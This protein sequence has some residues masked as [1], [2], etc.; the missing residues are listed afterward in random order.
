MR[1]RRSLRN[2]VQRP[3]GKWNPDS[4]A[5]HDCQDDPH[6]V[7]DLR[8]RPGDDHRDGRTSH[9]RVDTLPGGRGCI[10]PGKREDETDR[11]NDV[12]DLADRVDHEGRPSSRLS[13]VLNIFN[14][15]SVMRNPLTM[16]VIEAKRAIAPRT[17]IG[18]GWSP[19]V[20]RID[21]TTAIAEMALV[22]DI[23]GVW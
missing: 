8:L 4:K 9:T 15:R 7:N 10:H 21:P 17:R 19:P 16:F 23:N 1:Q 11:S 14:M 20:I 5:C 13:P 6:V 2:G 12:G 3:S 18:S 22:N